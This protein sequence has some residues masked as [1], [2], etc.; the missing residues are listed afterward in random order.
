MEPANGGRARTS[1]LSVVYSRSLAGGI[2][3]ASAP[4]YEYANGCPL[5]FWHNT[6]DLAARISLVHHRFAG[7]DTSLDWAA[8][9][10]PQVNWQV[11]GRRRGVVFCMSLATSILLYF[12]AES[13]RPRLDLV[14]PG[15]LFTDRDCPRHRR[16]RWRYSYARHTERKTV[17]EPSINH[18]LSRKSPLIRPS[19]KSSFRASSRY[20]PVS[21]LV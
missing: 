16:Y 2:C 9:D 18:L 10:A 13:P 19:N 17:C 20:A 1:C 12:N 5:A 21:W 15:C 8:L 6:G 14:L 11:T 3:V 4:A 7:V